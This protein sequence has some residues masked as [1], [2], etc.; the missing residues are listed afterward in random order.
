MP[1]GSGALKRQHHT[2]KSF[3]RRRQRR[4]DHAYSPYPRYL[5]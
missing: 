3:Y 2:I 5:Y 1:P 4:H